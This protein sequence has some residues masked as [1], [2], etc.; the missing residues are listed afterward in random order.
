M[1]QQCTQLMLS[2][3]TVV[4]FLKALQDPVAMATTLPSAASTTRLPLPSLLGFSVYRPVEWLFSYNYSRILHSMRFI[5]QELKTLKNIFKAVDSIC[6]PN[7]F[8]LNI[9]ANSATEIILRRSIN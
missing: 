5:I 2:R 3:L 7:L 9:N 4:D 8:L 1:N 6:L